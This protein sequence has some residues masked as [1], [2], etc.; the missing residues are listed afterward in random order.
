[1]WINTHS[2]RFYCFLIV[3]LF[4]HCLGFSTIVQA[5]P[6]QKAAEKKLVKVQAKI[7]KSQQKLEKNKGEIGSL[8]KQLRESEIHIGM[9]DQKINVTETKLHDSNKNIQ[10]LERQNSELQ[11]KLLKHRYAL[12]AQIRSEYLFGGQEKLKLL[13]NQQDPTII[14]RT[15][16]YYDYLHRARMDEIDD[17]TQILQEVEKVQIQIEKEQTQVR[18]TH[19][20]LLQEK[21][22]I[23]KEKLKRSDVLSNLEKNITTEES[24]LVELK[25]NEEQLKELLEQLQSTLA[26]IPVVDQGQRFHVQK[27]NLYWPVVGKPSNKFGQKRNA[28]RSNLMWEGVY[29]PSNEDNN[30]RSI[31]H[32]RVVFAEWMRGLGLLII[33]DHGHGYMSLYGHNKS[34]YKNVGEWAN[35]GERIATVGLSGGKARAGLYFEIRKN[36]KPVNPAAWCTKH[37]SASRTAG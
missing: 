24:K 33:V 16:V 32:G 23:Q 7:Q 29:I 35:A 22:L 20:T 25:E 14:G 2:K 37:A 34:L 18:N 36:G 11:N 8:E 10:V 26:K 4:T 12:Y 15:L 27:G 3:L 31:F 9:L 1:M 19:V 6:S 30:I 5:E 13:L 17:A 28:A 21:K